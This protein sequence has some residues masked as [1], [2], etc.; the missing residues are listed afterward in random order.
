MTFTIRGRLLFCAL[1][2]CSQALY[3]APALLNYE[4]KLTNSSNQPTT[5][6]VTLTFT[7]WD[8]A[9]GGNQLGSGFSDDDVV[10]PNAAGVVSTQVGDDPG[11]G[12]PPSVFAFDSVWL[13]VQVNGTNLDPRTRV[14]AAAYALNALSLYGAAYQ[15]VEVT[16]DAAKNGQNLVA[17]YARVKLLTPHGQALSADNRAV[18]LVPPGRYDM[19]TGQLTMDTQFVDLVG[20]STA[21]DDQH[22]FGTAN[23]QQTGVLRQTANDVRIENLL[24][25]CTRSSGGVSVTGLDQCAYLP[26]DNLTATVVRNCRFKADDTNAFGMKLAGIYAGTY[27]NCVA[28]NYAFGGH[29]GIA[30]GTFTN[31]SGGFAFAGAGTVASG[32]FTNC[33]GG[34][35][36]FAGSNG[37]GGTASGTFINCTGSNTSFG[38]GPGTTAASGKF[39]YC[40][41][42]GNSYPS[43]GT[44]TLLYCIRSGA[45]YP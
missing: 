25:D 19:G 32:T 6:P 33:T 18:V 13:K 35:Y 28:Q 42:G 15:V 45:V 40:N 38:G 41:A 16:N 27:E 11:A 1:A 23:G 2:L 5:T 34:Q 17:A 22:I 3:A 8:A 26:D 4:A 10:T 44:P 21:R 36:A 43:S 31:C 7:F 12:I 14:T 24:I 29:L 20:L 30:S 37:S 9:S 39:Y